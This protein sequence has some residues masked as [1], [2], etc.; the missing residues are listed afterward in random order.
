M[1]KYNFK[2]SI[3]LGLALVFVL[4]ISLSISADIYDVSTLNFQE[5]LTYDEYLHLYSDYSR[6]DQ[7]II[8]SAFDYT[9]TDMDIQIA[10]NLGDEN[11][12]AIIT[13]E[14]GFVEYEFYVDE[15]GFYNISLDYF[16]VEGRTSDI[17]RGLKINGEFPFED[18]RYLD[19]F[20]V[21]VN[22]GEIRKDNR[23]NEISPPQKEAPRWLSVNIVDRLGYYNEPFLFFFEEG[24]NTLTLES[25]R[26]PMAINHLRLYQVEDRPSYSDYL[27]EMTA[28]GYRET[29]G[30][31]V[32]IL[33]QDAVAKSTPTIYPVFDQS[34]P[35]VVPYHHALI[36]LNTIGGQRWQNAGEWVEWEV[37][38]PEAGL[39]KIGF[40]AKQNINRGEVSARRL[41]INGEVPF[42]EVDS[43]NFLFSSNYSMTVPGEEKG[44]AYYFYF[45]EGKNIIRMEAIMGEMASIIR[46]TEDILFELNNAFRQIIM[47]TSSTPDRHR[48]YQLERRIP[49]VLESLNKYGNMLYDLASEIEELSGESGEQV[50][51]LREVG[52]QML[53]MYDRPRTIQRRI[54]HFRDT[55]GNLGDWIITAR[56]Q[57]LMMDY[58]IVA[59]PEVEMP[60]VTANI[61]QSVNHELRKYI[62]SYFVDYDMVGDVYDASELDQEPITVWAVMGRDNAQILKRMIE[63]SFTPE[64]GI[65]VNLEL[66]NLGVLLPA[67]LAGRGPDLALGIEA[68]APMNFAMRNAAFDLTQFDDFEEISQRFHESALVTYTFRDQVY[69]LPQQQQFTMM[70]YRQDILHDLGLGVPD[71]WD[72]VLRIIP[73]LKENNLEFGF[74]IT[75]PD[76]RRALSADMGMGAAGAGSISTLPGVMPF[77]TFL[78]QLGG[79]LYQADGVATDLHDEAAVEA[80]RMWT[81]FYELYKL[82]LDFSAHNRFRT[83]EMPIVIENY[84]MYNLLQI[85]A[86]EIRGKWDFTLIPGTRRE[87]G[88][89]D[90][91]IPSGTLAFRAGAADMILGH[92]EQPDA[93]WEFLKW[94]N[95]TETQVRYGRELESMMGVAAR[96]P[97][98]NREASQ[99]L[100]WTIDEIEI[101]N[102]QWEYLK[103]VPEVPGGYMT[104][105]H[106]DNAFRRVIND[107]EDDRKMLLDYVRIIEEELE[108]KRREFGLETDI[109]TMLERAKENPELYIWWE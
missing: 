9:D 55:L 37:E 40:K 5:Y 53:D 76:A 96:F 69:A 51:R 62:S 6:P 16:P 81:D 2:Y 58:F 47:I 60:K 21:W 54:N 48:D 85:F 56:E 105:R 15:A 84:P 29:E 20:R 70:F 94:W 52:R 68:D 79:D 102:E 12:D 67:T 11:I 30:I 91:T 100:P 27:A 73:E 106:L 14:S 89:I 95:S 57:P 38:V 45:N 17:T 72:D 41:Y 103:G 42:Q 10:E 86:P 46:E 18:A 82:P 7:E 64:T 65:F 98:A 4:A 88:T 97:T 43:I 90:R 25:Q 74:P 107:Q 13:E 49:H 59:S 93:S 75:P 50:A 1:K 80:F 31:K 99:L 61:F 92:T 3:L 87:D 32:R 34:D 26:E 28:K 109:D 78:Y 22:D 23:G 83:G 108:L 77:V 66:V 39:Y 101:I 44:E 71:T 36:R 33:A 104:G 19:F 24:L 35:T 8:I 63:D